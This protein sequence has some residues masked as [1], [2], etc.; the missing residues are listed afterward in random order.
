MYTDKHFQL[1]KLTQMKFYIRIIALALLT[2]ICG[3]KGKKQETVSVNPQSTKVAGDLAGYL[4]IIDGEY[5]IM[6]DWGG[7]MSIKIKALKPLDT[8]LLKDKTIKLSASLLND[9]GMPISGTG[10]FNVDYSSHETFMSLVKRGSGEEVILLSSNLGGYES[11]KHADKVK[12]FIVSSSLTQ[13]IPATITTTDPQSQNMDINETAVDNES[14]LNTDYDELLNSY[15]KYTDD[16]VK[17]INDMSN[18]DI[19]GAMADYAGVY[20]SSVELGQKLEK[21]KGKL[22][23]Q[24]LSRMMKIQAKLVQAIA[25]ANEKM[26]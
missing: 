10:E 16:Y 15:D 4:E 3:C 7:K 21:A 12:K 9:D 6:D 11:E 25:K 13:N 22:S 24:Q 14:A 19:A 5:E 2:T 1:L 8:N 18:D 17:L 26:K 20:Q 23:S